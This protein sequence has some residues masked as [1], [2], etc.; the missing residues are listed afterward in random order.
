[1]A[2]LGIYLG[3]STVFSSKGSPGSVRIIALENSRKLQG[4]N[5]WW[6]IFLKN[7]LTK[8]FIKGGFLVLISNIS[9]QLFQ[10]V[11]TDSCFEII[12]KSCCDS[13]Y[14]TKKSFGAV[15][16]LLWKI[17]KTPGKT[18][19]KTHFLILGNKKQSLMNCFLD[20]FSSDYLLRFTGKSV[21]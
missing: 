16:A 13:F 21:V 1:M 19:L 6:C 20:I 9:D 2:A 5:V 14:S 8:H 3:K 10:R 18:S 4:K 7:Y 11:P 17:W 12:W 15:R